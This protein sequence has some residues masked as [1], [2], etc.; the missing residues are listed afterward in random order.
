M[1][2]RRTTF[3]ILGALLGLGASACSGTSLTYQGCNMYPTIQ[4]GD[5]I[6]LRPIEGRITRNE[7]VEFRL[8]PLATDH[9]LAIARIVGLPGETISFVG[10]KVEVDGRPLPEPYLRRGTDTAIAAGGTPV[11]PFAD[12]KLPI[13]A[14]TYFVL[15]DN[16]GQGEDSRYYGPVGEPDILDIVSYSPGPR[17]QG[18]CPSK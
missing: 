13:P 18:A 6:S 16:R 12:T 2:G 17:A 11:F 3:V 1:L 5:G 10:G 14:K 9:G 15:N 7:I 8:P 4:P